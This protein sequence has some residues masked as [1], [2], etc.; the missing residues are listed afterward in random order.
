M[1]EDDIDDERYDELC[2]VADEVSAVFARYELSAADAIEVLSAM[3][4]AT[5]AAL[6]DGVRSITTLK[7]VINTVSSYYVDECVEPVTLSVH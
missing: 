6:T 1:T 5:T 3:L 2:D 4:G 7:Q